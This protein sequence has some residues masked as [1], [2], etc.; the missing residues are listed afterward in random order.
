MHKA[1]KIATGVYEYRG[2][3][4]SKD[5]S[6]WRSEEYGYQISLTEAKRDVDW[7]AD[8]NTYVGVGYNNGHSLA[9]YNHQWQD[10]AF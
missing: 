1:K 2:V 8:R 4:I 9:E 6:G 5:G 7:Y 10:D 3:V